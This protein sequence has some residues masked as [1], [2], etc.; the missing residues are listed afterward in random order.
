MSEAAAS[1]VVQ[2]KR[3]EPN[4]SLQ[5][6]TGKVDHTHWWKNLDTKEPA[7]V[8]WLTGCGESRP[9]TE[10]EIELWLRLLAAGPPV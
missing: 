8:W 4:Y 6:V 9:A 1:N 5:L 2:L 3:R 10:V 7:N